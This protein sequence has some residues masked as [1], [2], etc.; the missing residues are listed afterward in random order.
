MFGAGAKIDSAAVV[1][2]ALN[3]RQ[4]LV[5]SR[6]LSGLGK[7][8]D[9]LRSHKGTVDGIWGTAD[10]TATGYLDERRNL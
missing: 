3:I 7:T 4:A 9:Y 5:K 6:P 10:V 1:M 2:Q 8:D